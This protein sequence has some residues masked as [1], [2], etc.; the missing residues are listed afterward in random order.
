MFTKVPELTCQ[1][2]S[3]QKCDTLQMSISGIQLQKL[4][5]SCRIS[6]LQQETSVRTTPTDGSLKPQLTKSLSSY[7]HV[8]HNPLHD[9]PDAKEDGEKPV[10]PQRTFPG[11]ETQKITNVLIFKKHHGCCA[12]K[13]SSENSLFF[14]VENPLKEGESMITWRSFCP[15]CQ[16][17]VR[18]F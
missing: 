12:N 7:P 4:Q 10:N 17:K 1:T 18:L 8:D 14:H 11:D 15:R 5:V 13:L 2:G 9:S 6:C 16:R 3:T